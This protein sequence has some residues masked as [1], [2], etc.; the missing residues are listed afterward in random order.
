MKRWITALI[1]FFFFFSQIAV[2]DDTITV[3]IYSNGDITGWINATANGSAVFY[4]Q[5]IDILGE[6]DSLWSAVKSAKSKAGSAYSKASKA[7][8]IAKS[9]SGKISLMEADIQNNTAK[10]YI[11]RDELVSFENDYIKFKN[12]TLNNITLLQ[13][14]LSN[15]SKAITTLHKDLTRFKELVSYILLIFTVAIC[16]IYVLF[17]YFIKKIGGGKK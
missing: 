3:E 1:I 14:E 7:Y 5:G 4:I 6:I 8:V 12:C 11:L 15:Q 2:A 9:N 10:I 16:M 13:L 17:P